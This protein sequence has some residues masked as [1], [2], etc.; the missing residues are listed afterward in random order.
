MDV[1]LVAAVGATM[2]VHARLLAVTF[3]VM[4]VAAI[5]ILVV[6]DF[7]AKIIYVHISDATLWT[8]SVCQIDDAVSDDVALYSGDVGCLF[9]SHYS[10]VPFDLFHV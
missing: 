7:D 9:P 6:D 1:E 10:A 3:G 8:V 4:V 2:V 5:V